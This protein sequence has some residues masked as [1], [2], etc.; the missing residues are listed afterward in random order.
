MDKI[1]RGVWDNYWTNFFYEDSYYR[2]LGYIAGNPL[3]HGVVKNWQELKEYK[4]C[5]AKEVVNRYGEETIK[6]LIGEVM[7]LNW[8]D[9]QE[10]LKN[11][12]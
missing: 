9:E 5:N 4:Y 1:D 11:R 10:F 2:V 8:E 12:I 3:K 7:E 6:D